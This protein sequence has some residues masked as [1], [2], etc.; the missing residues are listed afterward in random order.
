[1]SAYCEWAFGLIGNPSRNSKFPLWSSTPLPAIA[2]PRNRRRLLLMKWMNPWRWAGWT[3]RPSIRLRLFLYAMFVVACLAGLASQLWRVQIEEGPHYRALV[4]SEGGEVRV[5]LPPVRGAI[6]DR[7]G[8]VLAGNEATFDLEFDLPEIVRS[9]R[10]RHGHVPT[11][12]YE[13]VVHQM[14]K[15]M[16]EPDIVRI[17]NE[18][19]LPRMHA[20]GLRTDYDSKELE[21]HFRTDA[22]VPFVFARNVDFATMAEMDEHG[23]DLSGAKI[24]ERPVR[25]YP[26]WRARRACAGLRGRSAEDFRAF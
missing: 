9:Y 12:Q 16:T 11:L 10:E 24:V 18:D 26:L 5:R 23:P 4:A 13:G 8:L 3:R 25:Q 21:R 6:C 7:N 1:M 17:V 19:V 22:E 15:M 20:L 2:P 14:E